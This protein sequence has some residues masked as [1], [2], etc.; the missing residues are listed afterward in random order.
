MYLQDY[1]SD[2][3]YYGGYI[4][5]A[6]LSPPTTTTAPVG[7]AEVVTMPPRYHHPSTPLPTYVPKVPSSHGAHLAAE[8]GDQHRGAVG[9]TYHSSTSSHLPAT[10]KS[11]PPRWPRPR[12]PPGLITRLTSETCDFV[13]PVAH[14]TLRLYGSL[15]KVLAKTRVCFRTLLVKHCIVKQG[16]IRTK[17]PQKLGQTRC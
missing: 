17:S 5:E 14:N 2:P 7:P 1:S 10:Y 16:S 6:T 3:D 13:A 8:S 12:P 11:L 9:Y 4:N 15:V